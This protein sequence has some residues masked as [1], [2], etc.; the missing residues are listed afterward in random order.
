MKRSRARALVAV[1]ALVAASPMPIALAQRDG[2]PPAEPPPPG[3]APATAPAA[4]P[5]ATT[6]A[7]GAAAPLPP[8]PEGEGDEGDRPPKEPAPKREAFQRQPAVL[9]DGML[10]IPGGRFTM[11]TSDKAAP[12]NERPARTVAVPAFWIDRTEVTVGAYRAC[13]DRGACAVLPRSSPMCT[14]DLGDP[15][16]PVSCVP[17]SSA[18]AYCLAV[19]KRLPREVEWENAARGTTPIRYPWGGGPG[20]GVAAMLAGETTNRSCAGKRP[21][22]V[23]SHLGGAS[24]YGVLD[25]SGNVEEWVADWYA[26]TFSELSPRAGASHVLRGGGWL[27]VPSL[28]RTTSRNWGSVREAGPNVGFRCAR[29]D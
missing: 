19:G 26:D 6:A 15:Q 7:P 14:L 10:R 5:A 27:T 28:G 29:D 21:S 24:P 23:G 13:I 18:N 1:G 8:A 17:W 11:G 16:L 25:M 2:G 12:A 20:C 9:K 4:P 3:Q 22:R